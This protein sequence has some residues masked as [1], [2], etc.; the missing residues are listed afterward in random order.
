[1]IVLVAF[2][3]SHPS[4]L[5]NVNQISRCTHDSIQNYQA[6]TKHSIP[7]QKPRQA[8]LL[9]KPERNQFTVRYK[10]FIYLEPVVDPPSISP[11]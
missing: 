5:R 1:M 4:Y 10:P 6:M 11:N 9:S 8:L 2:A 3:Y 7:K